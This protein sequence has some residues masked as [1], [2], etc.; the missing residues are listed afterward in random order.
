MDIAFEAVGSQG[1]LQKILVLLVF[2][3]GPLTALMMISNTFMVKKPDFQCKR[4]DQIENFK[5][6]NDTDLCKND[7][8]EYKKIPAKSLNNWA[9][10]FDLY[11]SKSYISPGFRTSFSMGGII[12]NI[13]LSPLPDS[14]GRQKIYKILLIA[15]FV[16]HLNVFLALNEWQ[17]LLS[18]FLLGIVSY[19]GAM[20]SIIITEFIDRDSAA[21]IM[22]LNNAVTAFSGIWLSLFFL[23]INSWRFLYFLSS[24]MAFMC[25]L[26]SQKYFL[27]SPRWLN[28]KN[29]FV[30]TIEVLKEIAKI[31]E[32]EENFNKFLAV[33][34]SKL[35]FYKLKL[36]DLLFLKMLCILSVLI[37]EI[38][39]FGFSIQNFNQL[40]NFNFIE[41][42]T[43][44]I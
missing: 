20:S 40:L 25:I 18:S 16:G 31:N 43:K 37:I 21:F 15:L 34:Q 36:I 27:E 26:M 44:N 4:K 33:N 28:S 12:G 24:L 9:Y 3:V 10:D 6:C 5:V 38:I 11:C 1:R 23:F 32:N 19:A 39:L 22:S 2:T 17:I 13:F 29:K 30:E 42:P 8:F 14:Y 7:F 35:F 41:I